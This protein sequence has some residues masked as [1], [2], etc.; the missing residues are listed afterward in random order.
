MKLFFL[1]SFLAAGSIA[2]AQPKMITQAVITTNTNVIA[3]EDED[4][5]QVGQG[6][7]GGEEFAWW[8]TEA[9]EGLVGDQAVYKGLEAELV[10]IASSAVYIE[11]EAYLNNRL[12]GTG[13]PVPHT[14]QLPDPVKRSDS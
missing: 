4:V 6:G 14:V 8:S 13:M 2:I 10:G 12:G 1:F 7:G 3:P 11:L 9:P 5:S